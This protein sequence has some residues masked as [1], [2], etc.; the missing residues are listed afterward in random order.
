VRVE[1]TCQTTL[2]KIMTKVAE[3]IMVTTT[4]DQE[5]TTIDQEMT[6]IDQEM[7]TIDQEMTTI[8]QEM[9]TIEKYLTIEQRLQE[10]TW[11]ISAADT[12]IEKGYKHIAGLRINYHRR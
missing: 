2:R 5:M 4:I 6:T 11:V 10:G 12:T 3:L 8:D 7:T 9:T 1:A